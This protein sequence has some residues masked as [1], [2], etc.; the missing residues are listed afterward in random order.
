MGSGGIVNLVRPAFLLVK[1]SPYKDN[2]DEKDDDEE[3][4]AAL[5]VGYFVG[6][7]CGTRRI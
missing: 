2:T 7:E 3:D 4:S 6:Q 1:A 5:F